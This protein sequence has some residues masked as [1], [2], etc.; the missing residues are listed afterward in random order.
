MV[1]CCVSK[2]RSSGQSGESVKQCRVL[3]STA[4]LLSQATGGGLE[5]CMLS[6]SHISYI[7]G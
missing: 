5:S 4:R 3:V 1:Q 6:T 7:I 2:R